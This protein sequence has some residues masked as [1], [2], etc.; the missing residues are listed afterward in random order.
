MSDSLVAVAMPLMMRAPIRTGY[1]PARA[2]QIQLPA[3]SNAMAMQVKR[4]PKMFEIGT[5]IKFAYPKART[6]EPVM[7]LSCVCE[8]PHSSWSSGN[9]GAMER[10]EAT[11]TQVY[12]ICTPMAMPESIESQNIDVQW[13]WE[14]LND[15]S[16]FQVSVQFRGSSAFSEG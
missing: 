6:H 16:H 5:M 4:R 9:I 14:H 1:D 13:T 10:A 15:C 11:V 12:T 3:P 7:R 8:S 2:S